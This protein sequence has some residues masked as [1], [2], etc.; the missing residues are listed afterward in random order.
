MGSDNANNKLD[1]VFIETKWIIRVQFV[2]LD[3]IL[4]SNR[5]R[6]I[7]GTEIDISSPFGWNFFSFAHL[8]S[9]CSFN[10]ERDM[11]TNTIHTQ[12]TRKYEIVTVDY[13]AI[14]P[15]HCLQK[16]YCDFLVV[17]FN[18]FTP[19]LLWTSAKWLCICSVESNVRSSLGR[20]SFRKN[21]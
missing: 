20:F 17:A 16:D 6:E 15:C 9:D 5:T 3:S 10:K 18:F 19:P 8:S 21:S 2:N 1:F 12:Y 7:A 11:L 14:E 13:A 4:D